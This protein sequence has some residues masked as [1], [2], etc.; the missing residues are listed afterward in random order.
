MSNWSRR[1]FIGTAAAGVAGLGLGGRFGVEDA[2]VG[3]FGEFPMAG[4]V[5]RFRDDQRK[6][7]RGWAPSG[8][9]RD[10][11]LRLIR[12]IVRFFAPLQ[13]ARGAIIDPYEKKE[14][15]YSTPA[16]ALGIAAL[17]AAGHDLDLLPAA[18][19]AMTA[20]CADL[21]DGKAADGHADFFTVLLVHADLLLRRKVPESA[22]AAWR[23]DLA[24]ID[25]EKIYRRQPTAASVNNWTLV[26]AAGEWL[27][28]RERFGTSQAWIDASVGRQLECFTPAGMY[29]DPSDPLAYDHFARLW[30]LDL[31]DEGYSGPMAATLNG[32]L[33]R[34]AWASLFM[35]SPHGE[36]P[37]GGRSAHHQWNEAEQ[38]VTFESFAGRS[39]R[40]GDTA[41]AGAFK[42]AARLSLRSIGRW[43][44]PSGELWIVK[45]R[46][47]PSLR[48]G[49][50]Y[51]SFHSQYNLLTAAMLAIAWSRADDGV[52][53]RPCPA[54]VG[55][56]GFALQPAFHKAF[57][58]AGGTYIEIDTGAD[59]HYNPT[60]I[61]RIHR[62]DLPPETLSDGVITTADYKVPAKPSRTLALGPA[63]RDRAG[64]W[65]AL[66]DHAGVDLEPTRF[67]PTSASP[68]RVEF[69]ATYRGKLRGGATA[70]R[71]RVTVSARGVIEIEHVVE[72][73]IAGVRQIYPFLSSDGAHESAIKIRDHV[74]DIVRES[75]VLRFEAPATSAPVQRLGISEPCRNGFMDAA[76][77]ES[78]GRTIRCR[79]T[80]GRASGPK[81][82]LPSAG[83]EA[84]AS[85]EKPPSREA[86]AAA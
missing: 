18:V 12:G 3:R 61:L 7:V 67:T 78:A 34:G 26:A 21:A 59:P 41:V 79:V 28:T 2:A 57:A 68:T 1:E 8:L 76:F 42:R 11:Y 5:A 75:G 38:A 70:V 30:V 43:V 10:E 54:E 27:R 80:V 33:E 50:E 60:G 36:L 22:A 24:R 63:W 9:N 37:C 55:G 40:R 85:S 48:H 58:N 13:D 47:D 83:S 62:R 74:A 73:D 39:A 82:P 25:P 20:A 6:P 52:V 71:E 69:E 19:K 72:G 77:A 15:Q 81:Q 56:F 53:E 86:S 32:L 31:I 29:R 35:Q 23:R 45:N 44:R 66:A 65:H 17:C 4:L 51:Y 84:P 16:F 49:Y 14:R 64:Q 46:V